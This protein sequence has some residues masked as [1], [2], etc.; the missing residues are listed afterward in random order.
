M[1]E[2]NINIQNTEEQDINALM[3]VRLDKLKELCDEGKDPF[4]VTKFVRTHTSAQIK[5][6]YTEEE[7]ELTKRGSD[8]V[9]RQLPL[10]DV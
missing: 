8:E 9:E 7:R 3:K 6:N 10:Q 1:S 4:E 5:D 2:N